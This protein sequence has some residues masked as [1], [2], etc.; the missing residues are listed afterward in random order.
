MALD[1]YYGCHYN[2]NR[3]IFIR[4]N[5]Q[6][7]VCFRWKAGDAYEVEIIDYH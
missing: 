6:F 4:I 2:I 3:D 5:N 1:G 7:R